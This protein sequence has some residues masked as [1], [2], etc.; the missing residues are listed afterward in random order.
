MLSR[1]L[2]RVGLIRKS[3][4]PAS[5][6]L[7]ESFDGGQA[8]FGNHEDISPSEALNSP[9]VAACVR[10]LSESVSSLPF[11]VLRQG[12][13]SR[14]RETEHPACA[15][16]GQSPN[17]YQTSYSFRAKIVTDVI[18]HGNFY[19]TIERDSEG[20]VTA[21]WPLNPASVTI[22]TSSG[23]LLYRVCT[24]Q[25]QLYDP[26][27]LLH[28]KMFSLDGICGQSLISIAK[29]A[30]ILDL[31]LLRYSS[32]LFEN[33]CKPG[34]VFSHPG[35]LEEEAHKNLANSLKKFRRSGAGESLILEEGMTLGKVEFRPVDSKVSALKTIALQDVGRAMRVPNFLINEASR[36]TFHTS[37]QEQTSFIQSSLR[38]WLTMIESEINFKLF[39]GTDLCASF[40]LSDLLRGDQ[41]ERYTAYATGIQGGFLSVADVRRAENLPVTAGMEELRVP[42]NM[43]PITQIG[44]QDNGQSASDGN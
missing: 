19:A 32:S 18:L 30:I 40:D 7:R 6:M 12:A 2:D 39:S 17:S 26:S 15:L 25:V 44:A 8:F 13:D 9:A 35:Q 38:P 43:A 36:S 37:A 29:R 24:P 22:D 33:G 20:S 3:E 28:F 42:L 41:S 21:L 1:L 4:A 31:A 16:L 23:R 14:E 34:L 5:Y 27:Q 11:H 10:L